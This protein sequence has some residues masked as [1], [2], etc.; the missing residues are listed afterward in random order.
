MG[1]VWGLLRGGVWLVT[2]RQVLA[3]PRLDAA[4]A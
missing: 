3:L 4:R 1:L 2:R